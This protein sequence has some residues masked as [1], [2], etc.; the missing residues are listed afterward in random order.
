MAKV[1]HRKN[2]ENLMPNIC[3]TFGTHAAAPKILHALTTLGGLAGWWT[4][5]T[6]GNP[7][8]GGT[9]HFTFGGNG[10]FDMKVIKS[11]VSQVHWQCT[12]GPEDWLGTQIECLAERVRGS[13]IC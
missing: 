4:R 2:K 5:E 3:L 9:I 7:E 12:K 6:T 10:G 13:I 1:A 11:D 8:P